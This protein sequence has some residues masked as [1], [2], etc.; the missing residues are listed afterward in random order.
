MRISW[1]IVNLLAN[2]MAL[3]PGQNLG[4]RSQFHAHF[5]KKTA[6]LVQRQAHDA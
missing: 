2:T 5:G 4:E 3:S 6:G 1:S